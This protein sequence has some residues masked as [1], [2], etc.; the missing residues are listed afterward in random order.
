[1]SAPAASSFLQRNRQFID[2]RLLPELRALHRV[3]GQVSAGVLGDIICM[4]RRQ[5]CTYLRALEVVG[6]VSCD[7]RRKVWRVV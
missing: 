7:R 5:V 1:M 2:G 3:N 4:S 6:V